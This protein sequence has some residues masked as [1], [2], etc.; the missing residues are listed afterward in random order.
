M[1]RSSTRKDSE[2]LSSFSAMSW[3]VNWAGNVIRWSVAIDPVPAMRTV[4]R[5]GRASVEGVA[6]GA[7][8]RRVRV[9][10]RETLLLDRVHEVDGRAHQV[11]GAHLVGHD[12]HAAELGDDVAV[13]VALVEVELVAKARAAARLDRDAQLQLVATLFP[14]PPPP[15]RA[16]P[17]AHPHPHPH[18]LLTTHHTS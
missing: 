10:D 6:A 14:H 1:G 4:A 16:P 5:P 18:P 7:G 15:P 8:T 13:D 17:P 9:V 3:S 2:A 12:L 11:R